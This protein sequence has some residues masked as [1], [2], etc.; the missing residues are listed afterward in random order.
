MPVSAASVLIL[1]DSISASYGM[2]IQQGWVSQLDKRL[3]AR[4]PGQH[5][6]IN[7]SVSG[8]TTTGGLNR[9]PVL[10][11]QHKPD[12][13]VLELGANDGLRGQPPALI[14]RNLEA[15]IRLSRQSGARVVVLGMRILPNYGKAY[16]EAFAGVFPAAAKSGGASVLP[17][18]L[19]GVGGVPALMQKDGIH[20]NTKAQPLLLE[21]AWPLIIDAVNRSAKNRT[22]R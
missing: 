18:F 2:D 3:A 14:K 10:L 17:F 5:T 16:S 1:G 4:S 11:K 13:V 21:L 12:V 6:V 20:P 15:M 9:L 22:S 8:E 19:A 7:A